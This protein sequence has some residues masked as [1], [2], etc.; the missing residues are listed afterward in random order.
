MSYVKC[1]NLIL[2]V[3]VCG[4]GPLKCSQAIHCQRLDVNRVAIA[5]VCVSEHEQM[6]GTITWSTE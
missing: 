5:G 1:T 4:V 6:K 3:S 2:C